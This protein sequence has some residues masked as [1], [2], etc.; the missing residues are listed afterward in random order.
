MEQLNLN[1][2]LHREK[3]ETQLKNNLIHFEQ[4]KQLLNVSRGFYVYG[5]PGV[6]KTMFVKKILK[7]LSYDVIMFDSSDLRN[8]HAIDTITK[9][10]MSDRTI[11]SMFTNK[12]KKIAIIMDEI[13]S[14][15]TGDKSGITSLISLIRA[16]KTKKQKL[17]ASTMVPVIC[18]GNN[19]R[20]KKIKE[21]IK[22]CTNIYIQSP[23]NMQVKHIIHLL[24][25][26]LDSV[27]IDNIIKLISGDL[28][29]LTSSHNI[30]KK[31]HQLLKNEIIQNIF[32]SKTNS[33][34]TKHITK[35]LINNRVTF[36]EHNIIINET[37][38]TSIGL[39]FHENIIDVLQNTPVSTS[40]PFYIDVLNTIC[41]SDY[42]DR[43]TFQKQ[44]WIF[45]EISSLM[46]T[47]HCNNK[48]HDYMDDS[49]NY[50]PDEVRF[51]KV[52]TKY[53]TEYN[54]MTFIQTLCKKL[55]MD[56]KDMFTYFL[57]LRNE[58]SMNEIYI[59]L[60][61]LEIQKLHIN[62]IYKF[63]DRYTLISEE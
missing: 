52:L 31:Q 40:I 39:L 41:Y 6:G 32:Q 3:L 60:E 34:D 56:K 7:D 5:N 33:E 59:Q 53:S 23:T 49:I 24:M 46:K 43:I 57:H 15:N 20:D 55:N 47:I 2:I 14:M 10:N 4:N 35:K 12:P 9:H 58:Y 17:E 16:K 13:D 28:R 42:I 48:L 62:R 21:L 36:N 63:I 19:H 27:L 30:Y 38:R 61:I 18:I 54:N 25:P 11:L 45:N 22:V 26:T 29:K 51:T 37:N 8:K 50:N 44:V 1:K